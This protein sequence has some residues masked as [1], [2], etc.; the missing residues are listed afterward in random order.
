MP[1]MGTGISNNASDREH[2][3]WSYTVGPLTGREFDRWPHSSNIEAR[4]ENAEV[5]MSGTTDSRQSRLI[6][7]DIA[8]QIRVME[9]VHNSRLIQN[10]I[11]KHA[12]EHL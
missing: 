8:E 10:E 12:S 6:A 3:R 5:T 2:N 9:H 7:D 4:V 11:C 1:E